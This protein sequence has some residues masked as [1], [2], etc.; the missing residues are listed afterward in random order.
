[1]IYRAIN[2]KF[3]GNDLSAVI[4]KDI[5]IIRNKCI[6]IENGYHRLYKIPDMEHLVPLIY[7]RYKISD[8]EFPLFIIENKQTKSLHIIK[9][10][11]LVDSI[12]QFIKSP[13]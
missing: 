6:V 3:A 9:S 2:G 8:F 10:Q 4:Q 1:M 12:T 13:E 11:K 7:G 5:L